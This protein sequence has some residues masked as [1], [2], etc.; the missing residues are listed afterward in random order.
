MQCLPKQANS[1]LRPAQ[2]I[3]DVASRFI[4]EK[5]GGEPF[6]ALHVRPYPV[7]DG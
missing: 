7:R 3:R 5:M 2:W 4:E 1:K 6:L